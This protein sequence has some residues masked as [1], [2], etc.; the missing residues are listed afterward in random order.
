MQY[1]YKLEDIF[2]LQDSCIKGNLLIKYL[3]FIIIYITVT[4]CF[5]GR[6]KKRNHG[7]VDWS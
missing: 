3:L 4:K 5:Q 7:C 1:T 6:K 2:V